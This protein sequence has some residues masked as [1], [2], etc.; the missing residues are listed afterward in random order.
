MVDTNN[1]TGKVL[2]L[3]AG[4]LWTKPEGITAAITLN[5]LFSTVGGLIGLALQIRLQIGIDGIIGFVGELFV[6]S[7][8]VF[9]GSGPLL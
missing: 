1:G 3:A 6:V 2:R 4:S 7:A 9:R 8:E 5:A